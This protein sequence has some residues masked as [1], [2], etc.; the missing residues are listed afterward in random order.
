[1]GARQVLNE[2]GGSGI[3]IGRRSFITC[4]PMVDGTGASTTDSN[5]SVTR[6]DSFHQTATPNGSLTLKSRRVHGRNL[7]T[8]ARVSFRVA[9][10]NSAAE[11]F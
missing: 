6:A 11:A 9:S 7:T 2:F 3:P 8:G 4:L 1:M 10:V 5:A